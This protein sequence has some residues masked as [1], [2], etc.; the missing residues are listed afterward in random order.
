MRLGAGAHAQTQDRLDILLASSRMHIPEIS[1]SHTSPY[2]TGLGKCQ[3]LEIRGRK[4]SSPRR[5][6]PGLTMPVL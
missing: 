4:L 6:L 1:I 5:Q 3:K 2:S